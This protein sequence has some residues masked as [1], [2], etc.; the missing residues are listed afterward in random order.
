ML[1]ERKDKII[2]IVCDRC[3]LKLTEV[4]AGSMPYGKHQARLMATAYG[5]ASS[6]LDDICFGCSNVQ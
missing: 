5:W 4:I 2:E 3:G 6:P 1:F